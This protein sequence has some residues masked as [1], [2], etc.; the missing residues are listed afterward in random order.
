V[1]KERIPESGC[2]QDKRTRLDVKTWIQSTVTPKPGVVVDASWSHMSA[3]TL[4]YWLLMED[5]NT[6]LDLSTQTSHMQNIWSHGSPFPFTLLNISVQSLRTLKTQ[7]LLSLACYFCYTLCSIVVY[8]Y[9]HV[10]LYSKHIQWRG[11]MKLWTLN[12]HPTVSMA[13]ELLHPW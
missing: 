8:T 5:V 4:P 9:I 6:A 3:D 12:P 7:F 1:K 13:W 2:R 11:T 10:C